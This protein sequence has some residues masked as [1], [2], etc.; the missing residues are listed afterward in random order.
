MLAFGIIG[1]AGFAP[2]LATLWLLSKPLGMNYLLAEV[3]ANQVAIGWN[4]LLLDRLLFRHRRHQHWSGRLGKFLA[5]A[6]ADLIGRIP[7]LGL[8]VTHARMN[9]LVAT[10]VTLIISFTL[11]FAVTD[12]FIYLPRPGNRRAERVPG[13]RS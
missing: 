7:L 2:N 9:V 12:R 11:R 5:L 13:I 10:A 1:L 6:N 8:L 4:F 3:L